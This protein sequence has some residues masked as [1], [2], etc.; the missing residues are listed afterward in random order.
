MAPAQSRLF[1]NT[2]VSVR[3]S[4]NAK[5]S[6][7]ADAPCPVVPLVPLSHGEVGQ[8]DIAAV[9]DH[10][11]EVIRNIIRRLA[12]AVVNGFRFKG[13]N[14]NDQASWEPAR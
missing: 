14:P 5:G 7:P 1:P 9:R 13:G 2:R 11:Q 3:S 12:G 6:G 10:Q 4:P 8:E